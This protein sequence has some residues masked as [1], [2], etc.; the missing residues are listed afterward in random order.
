LHLRHGEAAW[1][2]PAAT[3]IVL[4]LTFTGPAVLLTGLCLVG[5]IVVAEYVKAAR[6]GRRL[7]PGAVQVT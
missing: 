1:P 4:A 5:L 2:I 6:A 7:A 3:A